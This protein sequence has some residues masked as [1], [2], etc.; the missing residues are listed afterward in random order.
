MASAPLPAHFKKC[1]RVVRETARCRT[2][3]FVLSRF[4]VNLPVGFQQALDSGLI[5]SASPDSPNSAMQAS[6]RFGSNR[7]AP[8]ADP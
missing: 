7:L 2:S 5:I 4:I 1:R 3:A 8:G 6:A